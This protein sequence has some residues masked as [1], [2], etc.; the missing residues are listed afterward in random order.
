MPPSGQGY[1]QGRGGRGGEQEVGLR[2]ASSQVHAAERRTM[3]KRRKGL[4][5]MEKMRKPT[6]STE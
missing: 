1:H 2:C 5:R 3:E 4:L 6:K